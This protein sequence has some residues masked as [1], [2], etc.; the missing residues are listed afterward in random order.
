MSGPLKGIRVVDMSRVLAG[1]SMTQIFADLG[2]EV[3][4]IERP[5]TGDDTRH[6]GPPWL[7]DKDGNDTK[8]AGYYLSTN[9][10]KHSLT[11]NVSHPEGAQ[12]VKDLA[13]E[14]DFFVENFKVGGLAKLGLDYESIKEINPQ[15]IYLSI[16][17]FGQTGPDAPLPGYDYLIQARSG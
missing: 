17:G 12:I 2:A 8:E 10:G 11:V 13:R 7:Q 15:I 1:P 9:R 6:W 16:T 5:G 14:A 4:K 3:I